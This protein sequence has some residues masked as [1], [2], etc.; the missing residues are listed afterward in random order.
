MNKFT[1]ICLFSCLFAFAQEEIKLQKEKTDSVIQNRFP[2]TRT[3]NVE[4]E[5]TLSRDFN[6]EFLEENFDKGEIINQRVVDFTANIPLY[7]YKKWKFST[8][9]N[10]KNYQF[11]FEDVE[12]QSSLF[13]NKRIL[14]ENYNYFAVSLNATYYGRLFKKPLIYNGSFIADGSNKGFERV[15]GL[16]SAVLLLKKTRLTTISVGL[17]ALIDPTAQIPFAPIFTYNQKFENSK[18]QLDVILPQRISFTKPI[19]THSRLTIGTFFGSDEF[20]VKDDKSFLP[21]VGVYSQLKLDGGI[22]Y[23]YYVAK[24]TVVTLQGGVRKFISNRLTEKGKE[25][26]DFVYKNSQDLTGYFNIGLSYN[27]FN[28]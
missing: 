23:E 25:N 12:N 21:K 20:Y 22:V 16:V 9:G 26:N 11:K 3:F 6:S 5:H 1:F 17:V 19:K 10:F 24:N 8:S 7:N 28:H 18:W 15:K 13:P 14:E 27:L 2:R 4:Y